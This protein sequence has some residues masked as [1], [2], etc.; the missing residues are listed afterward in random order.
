MDKGRLR[1]IEALASQHETPALAHAVARAGAVDASGWTGADMVVPRLEG[2]SDEAL[3]CRV[4]DR[5]ARESLPALMAKLA[6][7]LPD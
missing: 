5:L 2:E 1:R 7:L 6:D 3:R 4:A